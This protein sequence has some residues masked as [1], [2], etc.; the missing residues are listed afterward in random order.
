M[1]KHAYVKPYPKEFREQVVKLVPLGD[2]SA[3]RLRT[4]KK[5]NARSSVSWKV[6]ITGAAAI[7]RWAISPRWT[8]S[9]PG[10]S[11]SVADRPGRGTWRRPRASPFAVIHYLTPGS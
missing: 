6:S 5:R 2:R 8:S 3:L 4:A 10:S 9:G 11:G 7:R 1:S